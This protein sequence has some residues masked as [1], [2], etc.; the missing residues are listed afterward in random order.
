MSPRIKG[1]ILFNTECKI[2]T[3][4]YSYYQLKLYRVQLIVKGDLPFAFLRQILKL[5]SVNC[6]LFQV[7]TFHCLISVLNHLNHLLTAVQDL[8]RLQTN[9]CL[10]T[11]RIVH[12]F[13]LY[14][15]KAVYL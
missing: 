12:D 10:H 11:Y 5:K 1:L 7:V 9:F 15:V 14:I 2:N 4:N 6:T 13:Q 3:G 8:H